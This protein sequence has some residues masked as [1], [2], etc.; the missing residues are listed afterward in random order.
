MGSILKIVVPLLVVVVAAVLAFQ[1]MQ[2]SRSGPA[3][4]QAG[5]QA[6]GPSVLIST[7]LE[8]ALADASKAT[9][10]KIV[11]AD[12]SASW[13]GPC[14]QMKNEFWTR[15]DVRDWLSP[16]GVAV[17][18]DVDSNRQLASTY[19]ANAI[20]LLVVFKNG[21]EVARSEGYSGPDA[22]MKF[23]KSAAAK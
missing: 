9:P 3:S 21:K 7:P 19:K 10:P 15:S 12:F 13:C 14:Q 11:I 20:P 17:E 18:V 22:T 1:T 2:Q 16:L 8:K 23:L 6:G 4:G 5:G